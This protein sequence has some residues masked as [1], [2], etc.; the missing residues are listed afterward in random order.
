MIC[1][2]FDTDHMSEEGMEKFF[3]E[4]RL[5]GKC[6]FFLHKPF[7]FA[8]RMQREGWHEVAPHPFIENLSRW[9]ED[10]K[11]IVRA[12]PE[13]P[14]G[15]RPHSCVFSHMIGIGMNDLGYDYVSQAQNMYES[16]LKPFRHP[17]GVWELPI[18]YMDN[19]DFW[20][21]KN[22]PGL[23]HVP[24]HQDII[25]RALRDDSL[26]VFDFH[27]LHVILNTGR[28]E[29][30]VSVKGEILGKGVSPFDLRFAG[31]GTGTFFQGLCAAMES[32]GER[33]YT[34]LEALGRYGCDLRAAE[35]RGER[36][37]TEERGA[38]H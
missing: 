8:A 9:D 17:W 34:C 28:H 33:S 25:S 20:M 14:F 3:E 16:G 2:T 35:H 38:R 21:T 4:Y 26:Y 11:E 27:P 22:W 29:D 5:P 7:K 10:L 32:K 1:L 23:G 30:Y 6:T 37:K 18:Y 31:R 24:F 12:F 36:Q 15:L 13:K 19:M